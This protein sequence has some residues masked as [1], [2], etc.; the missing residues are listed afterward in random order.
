MEVSEPILPSARRIAVAVLPSTH[1]RRR[2]AVRRIAVNVSAGGTFERPGF[3][4]TDD[5][6]PAEFYL[7]LGGLRP[8]PT[9]LNAGARAPAPPSPNLT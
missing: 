9:P 1:C 8:P 5:V 7:F 3:V 4:L 2:C 6:T